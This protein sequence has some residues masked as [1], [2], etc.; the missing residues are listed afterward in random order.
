MKHNPKH[1]AWHE[2]L[3]MHEL[4]AFQAN[5]LM[6]FKMAL[7]DIQ[8]PQLHSL[9]IEAI[10]G[11]EN[12][13]KELLQ[14]F[15]EAPVGTR[16]LSE[17][18]L[19]AYYAGHLLGF[20]KTSVRNYAIAITETATPSLRETL[21]KQLNKAIELHG[22]VYYFMYERGLYPSYNLKQLLSNDV[23]NANK[24]ISL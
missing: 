17:A 12:N 24:A 10:Q 11:V 22:K 15:P 6:G 19:T 4:T 23:K 8:D 20:A 16:K 5:N 3:E 14:Y 9:Y 7:G 1:L 2:T 13:L 21:Q 18:D